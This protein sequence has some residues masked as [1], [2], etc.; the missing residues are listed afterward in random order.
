MT[1]QYILRDLDPNT[2][3]EAKARAAMDG[4]TLKTVLLR[5]L[6]LYVQGDVQVTT[7]ATTTKRRPV[8]G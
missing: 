5:L 8:G 2:W 7:R 6:A 3:Q 4:V 1:T